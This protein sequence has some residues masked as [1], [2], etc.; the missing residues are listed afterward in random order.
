MKLAIVGSRTIHS[1]NEN[2][3][4]ID[5]ILSGGVYTISEIVSGGAEG[6][7][8]IAEMYARAY[9]LKMT[10]FKPDW[11][12]FGRQAGFLRNSEIVNHCDKLIAFQKNESR[13]TADSIRKAKLEGKLLD[14]VNWDESIKNKK[15]LQAILD[16]N[17]DE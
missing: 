10:I 8:T 2:F 15:T 6:V 7:D 17:V 1:N 3:S 11:K 12:K 14:I 5:K 16:N 4:I 9:N 13:G